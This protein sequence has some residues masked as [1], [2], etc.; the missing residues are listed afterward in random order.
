[1]IQGS[2]SCIVMHPCVA[3]LSFRAGQLPL[4]KISKKGVKNHIFFSKLIQFLVESWFNKLRLTKG[5][6][7]PNILRVYTFAYNAETSN[8]F[9]VNL[10][11]FRVK[12]IFKTKPLFSME[13]MFKV[14]SKILQHFHIHLIF[15]KQT[16]PA[17]VNK[18]QSC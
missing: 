11:R 3:N 10:T 5:H 6:P 16:Q 14:W 13:E 1:M 7:R 9:M 15:P 8:D 2:L 17:E 18:D 12:G 4:K